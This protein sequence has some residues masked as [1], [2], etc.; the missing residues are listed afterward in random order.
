[1]PEHHEAR[2][3]Y[4]LAT[5][6]GR[7]AIAVIRMSGPASTAAAAALGA[8]DLVDRVAALR[9]LQNPATGAILDDALVLRFGAPRS[10]TGED[11]VEL[12]LH[13]GRAV[14]AG[15]LD[16]LG[17]I[18]GLHPAEPG[19]FTRQAFDNGRLDLTAAEGL[20]DLIDAET[21]AQ[22]D[23]AFRQYD[24]ALAARYERWRETLLEAMAL[25]EAGIDFSDEADVISD[26]TSAARSL[27]TPL[28][29]EIEGHLGAAHRGEIVRSGFRVVIAG[30][31]NAGK[32]SLI[33]ALAARDV[34]IVSPEAGTTRDVIEV[35]LDLGGLAVIVAD[36]AGLRDDGG[37]IEREGIRR[38][39]DRMR[40]ADLVIWLFDALAPE[41]GPKFGEAELAATA[42][43]NP[44]GF[45]SSVISVANKADLL[46]EKDRGAIKADL[47]SSA[48]TGEGL[49]ELVDEISAAAREAA[50]DH[51]AGPPPTAPRHRAHH[52]A[53][54]D[55]IGRFLVD[56]PALL[57]LRAEDLRLAAAE[58]G[59]LTG[60]IDP[61]DVLDVVFGR[62]CIGK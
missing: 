52:Q 15:V 11:V 8:R 45:K 48:R 39:R 16:A 22:R 10:A 38:A 7:S 41:P 2:T 20:A 5:P 43:Q 14:I 62:F 42:G 35:H 61:E 26:T 57:E 30:A 33:N 34:A 36:T 4:A 21:S 53:A 25:I 12:H 49:R 31:P 24:G 40:A 18:A 19:E 46:E 47:L 55:H 27:V 60:R 28:A 17:V 37:E 51:G 50:L 1:M 59:R 13:G 6:P 58:L 44:K 54:R 56:D 32:S 23:Q 29:A 3:I 9:R